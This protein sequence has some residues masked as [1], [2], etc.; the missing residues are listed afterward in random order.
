MGKTKMKRITKYQ[1]QLVK[2]SSKNYNVE[3]IGNPN[4]VY[5]ALEEVFR[6][7]LQAEEIFCILAL[8]TKHKIIGAFEVS[9][10]SINASIVH[11]REVFKR[12]MLV[13]ATKIIL[14][15]NHPSGVPEP[16]NEDNKITKRLAEAGH[17]LGIEVIDHI[18]V[19]DE[20]YHS[21]KEHQQI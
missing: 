10:G 4:D 11:P 3:K 15:H 17:I 7:S 1:L 21:Y 2:E 6:L 5:H 18:I 19:G 8:D 13:N 14:G 16:S 9:R 12:A 20:C